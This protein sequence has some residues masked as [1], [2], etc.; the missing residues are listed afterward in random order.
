V[1]IADDGAVVALIGGKDFNRSQLNL[2][3]NDRRPQAG[4][5]FKPFVLAAALDKG[6]TVGKT[7]AGPPKLNV[8]FPGF[9]S[10]PVSNFSNESF[11][12]INLDDATAHSVNTVYAQLAAEVGID[13]VAKTAHDLGVDSKLE[14][15]PALSLGAAN[16]SPIEM[17]RAY[18]TFANRGR[19]PTP[20]LV[21]KVTDRHGNVL[22]DAHPKT[23]DVYADKEAD[24]I[25]AVLS[26]VINKGT[27]TAAKIGR[28]A[29]GK[30]GTTSNNTDAWFVG[31]TP[32]LGTAVWMGY[33]EDRTRSMNRLHGIEATGGTFPAQIWQRFMTVAVK[34]RDTGRF[35]TPSPELMGVPRGGEPPSSTTSSSDTTS[36]TTDASTTSTS[37]PTD[38]TT[39]SSTSTSTSS[40]TST[41]S[42]TTTTTKPRG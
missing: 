3:T 17:V 13:K 30:T 18:M 20:Y 15:V 7:Y 40:T 16:V 14:T 27:G 9:P 26:D 5:T 12:S 39:T 41:T 22:F 1:S 37:S 36:T 29:A 10:F 4:S 21:R 8:R 25:N 42:P 38:S 23:D 6:I 11:G 28:P 19:R 35:T 2:A 34:G 32:K 24:A 31:Y 33:K